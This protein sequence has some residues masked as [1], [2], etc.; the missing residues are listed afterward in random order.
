M[1]MRLQALAFLFALALPA[2]AS[3]GSASFTTPG[4]YTFTTPAYGTLTV[5]VKGAGGGGGAPILYW[6]FARGYDGSYSQFGSATPV[7]GGGGG[8]WFST[9][10]YPPPS[11]PGTAAGGDS[12]TTGGGAA[13]GTNTTQG[14][15]FDCSQY[16]ESWNNC[17][18]GNG[19]RAVKTWESGAQGAPAPGSSISVVVGAGGQGSNTNGT[20][21]GGNPGTHG[22]V[23]VSW[24]D[25]ASQQPSCSIVLTPNPIR[26]G[27]VATLAWTSANATSF[28]IENVGYVSSVGSTV[29]APFETTLYAGS[30]S[31]PGGA[32][33]CMGTQTLVVNPPNGPSAVIWADSTSVLVGEPF[34][35]HATF[36][37]GSGDALTADNIDSPVGTGL[38]ASIAPDGRKDVTF[39]ASAPGT[40]TFYARAT[41][42]YFPSWTTYAAVSVTA[43]AA[44]SGCRP[45]YSCSGSD[46]VYTN[47]QCET[48]TV[49]A[50]VEP[51]FCSVGS[52]VCVSPGPTFNGSGT[53]TGHLQTVPS[54]LSQGNTTQVHWNVSYVSSCSVSGEN[55]DSW[56]GVSS[57]APGRTSS[58]IF[59]RTVYTLS[60]EG[61]D[62]SNFEERA[63]VNVVPVF[64]EI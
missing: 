49:A 64:E 16:E 51:F 55:G 8:G 53:L 59:E 29:V 60:C 50:C 35:V 15:N 5:D 26:Q 30:V 1:T 52:S 2:V 45:A 62:G 40:Y 48:S 19:G 4:T 31:G 23:I 25:A 34:G 47:P 33:N 14:V 46:I 28:Y 42:Q 36:S 61:L 20:Y 18:G 38:A 24:D 58:P 39:T 13:G 27:G 63:V 21:N 41:T 17:R 11:I 6:G 12:N 9:Y 56:I 7:F 54:I 44:N 37:A 22:S 10:G 43:Y 3:A 57:G 32:A